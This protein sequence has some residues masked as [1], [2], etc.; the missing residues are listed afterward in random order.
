[1]IEFHE[2]ELHM[3]F[4]IKKNHNE[5]KLN[6]HGEVK[7]NSWIGAKQNFGCHKDNGIDEGEEKEEEQVKS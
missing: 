2:I 6:C 1:M 7:M 3:K 4:F 5:M